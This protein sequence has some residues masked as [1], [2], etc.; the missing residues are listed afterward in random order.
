MNRPFPWLPVL[1]CWL[2]ARL[3]VV[4]LEANSKVPP[5]ELQRSSDTTGK[6]PGYLFR[7]YTVFSGKDVL[8]RGLS[9]TKCPLEVPEDIGISELQFDGILPLAPR[10]LLSSPDNQILQGANDGS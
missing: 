1:Q 2:E 4:C 7:S 10:N 5:S 3:S 6:F 9:V 8:S